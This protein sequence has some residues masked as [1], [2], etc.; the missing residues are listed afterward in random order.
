MADGDYV[1]EFGFEDAVEVFAGADGDEGVGVCKGR[2][3]ADSG[4]LPVSRGVFGRCCA[5]CVYFSAVCNRM[6]LLVRILE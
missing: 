4:G 2:E 6:D 1:L 5:V 3:D